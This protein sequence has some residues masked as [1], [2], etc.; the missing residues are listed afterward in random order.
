MA[1]PNALA[2]DVANFVNAGFAGYHTTNST[3]FDR[4]NNVA[5]LVAWGS[6]LPSAILGS[7]SQGAAFTRLSGAQV[8]AI[9]NGLNV[10]Q[11]IMA[12]EG[13]TSVADMASSTAMAMA[14]SMPTTPVSRTCAANPRAGR[15]RIC[16]SKTGE[17]AGQPPHGYVSLNTQQF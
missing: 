4:A 9:F 11:K 17:T 8:G 7:A 1:G 2:G 16:S 6:G 5:S 13:I 10:L 12:G 15:G 14:S 3:G